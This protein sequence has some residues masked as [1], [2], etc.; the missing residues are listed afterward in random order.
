MSGEQSPLYRYFQ[1]RGYALRPAW[2]QNTGYRIGWEFSTPL[3]T[4]TWRQEND[5]LLI[6]DIQSAQNQQGLESAMTALISLWKDIVVSVEEIK[7]IRGLPG[8]Y[9]TERERQHRKKMKQLLLHQ[10]AKE[11]PIENDVW[12]IYP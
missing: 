2:F 12:L 5:V 11:Y 7:Q 8:E 6:C 10:G 4:M 3:Y 1:L 9:G